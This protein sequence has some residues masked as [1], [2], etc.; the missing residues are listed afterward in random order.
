M[1]SEFGASPT[2]FGQSGDE[3]RLLTSEQQILKVAKRFSHS[4]LRAVRQ[5]EKHLNAYV[6]HHMHPIRC[7]KL[8]SNL[9]SNEY[10]ME[11]IPGN[12]LGHFLEIA[13]PDE[14]SQVSM[15]ICD[16][17]TTQRKFLE[18]DD[19]NFLH[20]LL[21]KIE[22]IDLK[23]EE[24]VLLL[25]N[26]IR[27]ELISPGFLSNIIS[28]WNH[29]DFSMENII[30][31]RESLQVYAIDFLNSPVETILLDWGRIWLDVRYGWWAKSDEPNNKIVVNYQILE[32]QMRK[33]ASQLGI[34]IRTLEFFA[35]LAVLRVFPYTSNPI[36]LEHL[37]FVAL[38]IVK[39]ILK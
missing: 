22:S 37:K 16:Y 19:T 31:D 28:E 18:A 29:G 33:S 2:K 24:N 30:V 10:Q 17:L 8:L 25:F 39:E 36:R 9:K 35:G 15:T 23:E 21:A 6:G 26:Q 5:Y 13:A 11:F 7:P 20:Y 27:K 32:K 3:V 12:V 38:A 1:S 4:S 14:V 34:E